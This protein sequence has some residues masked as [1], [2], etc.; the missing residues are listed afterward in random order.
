L[1]EHI[2]AVVD[3]VNAGCKVEAF[4][5]WSIIDNFEWARGYT[6]RFGIHHV[7][8]DSPSKTRTAKKSALFFKDMLPKRFFELP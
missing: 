2:S 3:A 6:E 7:D 8:F 1:K 5:V 4:T